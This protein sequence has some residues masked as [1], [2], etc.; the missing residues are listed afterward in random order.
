MIRRH[1][2]PNHHH[3]SRLTTLSDQIP[4]PLRHPAPQ[5]LVPI[6]RDPD[7][8]IL[9][10]VDRVRPSPIFAHPPILIQTR[11]KLTASKAVGLDLVMELKNEVVIPSW[12]RIVYDQAIR[13][14]GT[15]IVEVTTAEDLRNAFGRRTAMAAGLIHMGEAGNPFS[16]ETFVEAAHRQGVPVLIDAA[17]GTPHRPNPFLRR[18]VDLV[19]YSGGKIIRGPQTAGL[20]LGRKDLITAAFLNSAPHHSFARAMKVSTEEIMGLL[21]AVEAIASKPDRSE[22]DELWRGWYR[23]IIERVSQVRGVTG[24]ITEGEVEGNYVRMSIEWARR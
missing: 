4:C 20:L 13:S 1:R 8:V 7:Q 19:A 17:D 6:F 9:D 5:H 24:R 14:V 21:A 22:E 16:L 11:L 15:R 10:V 3:F 18:G 23:H 2:A 12:S